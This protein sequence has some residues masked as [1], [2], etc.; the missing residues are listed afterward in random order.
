MSTLRCT[1]HD[2][3]KNILGLI[4]GW[5][6]FLCWFL[7]L[8]STH[9]KTIGLYITP[10]VALIFQ[11][12][13]AGVI[14]E[15]A[16]GVYIKNSKFWN[17]FCGNWL[18]SY[19]FLYDL[20]SYRV[21]HFK[22]HKNTLFFVPEDLETYSVASDE[23][24]L[25]RKFL[26]DF[27]FVSA[28]KTF[29]VRTPLRTGA[30]KSKSL[31]I[32]LFSFLLWGVL[33]IFGSIWYVLIYFI[34]FFTLYLASTRIRAWATHGDLIKQDGTLNSRVARNVLSPIWERVFF[35]N[36]LHMYHYEHHQD[37]GLSFRDCERRA[38]LRFAESGHD[39]KFEISAPTYL[40]C[41]RKLLLN[42]R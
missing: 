38:V 31:N 32:G 8:P 1:K 13:I 20:D 41:A 36:R 12:F 6:A 25:I 37:M 2:N 15:T 3:F 24:T 23:K 5:V 30:H 17:D 26:N 14:H 42:R 11:Q 29:T 10:F 40:F 18:A 39:E 27:F 33:V 16:H 21:Q 28:W 7:I 22:H 34:T 35:G 19:L 4:W 9:F